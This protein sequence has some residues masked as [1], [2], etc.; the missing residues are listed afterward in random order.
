MR[1]ILI[2]VVLAMSGLSGGVSAVHAQ[3]QI[4][5]TVVSTK[6]T[7]CDMK[8]GSCEGDMVVDTKGAPGQVTI[9]VQKGTVIKHGDGHL[10]LPGTKG[11]TVA[12]TYVENKGEKVAQSIEVK[13]QKP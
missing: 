13:A 12:I 11:R 2:A 9:K 3:Q 8:P 10:F 5:G 6:M 4:E 1:G 7:A